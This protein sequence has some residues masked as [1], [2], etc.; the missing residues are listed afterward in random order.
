MLE[1]R[2][3]SIS[4]RRYTG[5]VEQHRLVCLSDVSLD[6]E[7]GELVAIVG[8]SGAGK[9]ILAHAILGLLPPNAEIAGGISLDGRIL[10][11]ERQAEMRGR[12]IALV[13]QSISFLDPLA[14]VAR[15][16][17]C[18]ARR[19][20]LEKSDL[21]NIYERS[22]GKFGLDRMVM[23]AFPHELSGGMA[24][25]LLLAAATI[26][27]PDLI[28]ADEPTTGLDDKNT[29][30]VLGY[31]RRIADDN[32]AVILITHDIRAAITVAD[33]VVVLRRGTVV[34][35]ATATSFRGDGKAL[36]TEY[37]RSLW[38]ALPE[39]DF[40]AVALPTEY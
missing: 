18:A 23:D 4:F 6:A 2:R 37:A 28:V 21:A 1:V 31:L 14:R 39:N 36:A 7:R 17:E 29:G 12:R 3:L 27:D 32:K 9:S 40:D 24:R 35:N 19:A 11:P 30:V 16:L 8:E 25:R 22:I 5:L 15:H 33:R 26:S 38:C 20:G 34:E 13:P 10:T